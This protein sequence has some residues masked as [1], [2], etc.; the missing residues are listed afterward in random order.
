MSLHDR[1]LT[2]LEAV[3]DVALVS[4]LRDPR[5]RFPDPSRLNV[6]VPDLHLVTARRQFRFGTNAPETLAAVLRRLRDFRSEA[7]PDHVVVYQIGDLLDLWRETDGLDPDADVASAIEDA[8]PDVIEAIYDAALDTQFLLGNHDYD[9]Y[10]WPNYDVWRRYFYLLPS[11]L[12][13]HGDIFD[14]IEKLPDEVQNFFVHLFAPNVQP[15]RAQLEAM[16]PLNLAMRASLR[17]GGFVQAGEAPVRRLLAPADVADAGRFNV[18]DAQSPPEMLRFFD[19]ARQKCGEVNQQ[20]GLDLTTLVIGH[21]HHARI[22]VHEDGDALFAL[23]DCGAWIEDCITEDDPTPRA[24][25]QI[26]AL[27]ENEIRIYQL[28]PRV[29]IPT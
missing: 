14:W 29:T 4:K 24:N 7:Q 22:V 1:L 15:G 17:P 10:R 5:L 18:Q 16:R 9:L 27:G 28:S 12:V 21:T 13:L 8:C 20:F 25:A 19:S 2:A 23:V 26:A 3:A 6:F 11:T